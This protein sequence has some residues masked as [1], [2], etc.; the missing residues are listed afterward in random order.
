MEF[1][2]G[3]PGVTGFTECES[4][5]HLR[6]RPQVIAVGLQ[7]TCVESVIQAG[8]KAM[9][10]VR[11][12]ALEIAL[13]SLL[14]T[15]SFDPWFVSSSAALTDANGEVPR[16]TFTKE[17]GSSEGIELERMVTSPAGYVTGYFNLLTDD[18]LEGVA[19]TADA[20]S[21]VNY[22]EC[23]WRVYTDAALSLGYAFHEPLGTPFLEKSQTETLP[24]WVHALKCDA[25]PCTRND[26][27][28]M[29][30]GSEKP[31]LNISPVGGLLPP[32]IDTVA[33]HELGHVLFKSYNKF[34]NS[35][36]VSFLNEGLPAGIVKI[37]L[38]PDYTPS[39]PQVQ[40]GYNLKAYR[41][42]SDESVR[43]LGYG[44]HPFWYF[45]GTEYTVLADPDGFYP[46]A[47]VPE[48]CGQYGTA[49]KGDTA[50]RKIPGRDVILHIQQAFER[51]HPLG[52]E[53]PVCKDSSGRETIDAQCA[54][55]T[56]YPGSGCVPAD[57]P[58]WAERWVAPGENPPSTCGDPPKPPC[59][60][61]GQERVGEAMMPLTLQM[62][63]DELIAH[64]GMRPDGLSYQ[65]FR[66]FLV[67]NYLNKSG[68]GSDYFLDGTAGYRIKS[69]GAHYHE[70]DLTS[71]GW[72]VRIEKKS[73]LPKWAY[74]VFYVDGGTAIS[75]GSWD[76][77]ASD[78]ITIH[79]DYEKAVLV[80]TAFEG[81]YDPM[82]SL[83]WSLPYASSGGHYT[84]TKEA[85]PIAPDV[86]DDG[87]PHTPSPGTWVVDRNDSR[88]KATPLVMP[89]DPHK[90]RSVLQFDRL[91]FDQPGDRD[92]FRVRIPD[93]PSDGCTC[94]C[95]W[96]TFCSKRLVIS[97]SS[98]VLRPT[99]G[100]TLYSPSGTPIDPVAEGWA[101]WAYGGQEIEILCPKTAVTSG[102]LS[103][104]SAGGE[105]T[106]S[107]AP[108]HGLA[109]YNLEIRYEYLHCGIPAFVFKVG[110]YIEILNYWDET[111]HYRIY[112]GLREEF[113]GCITDPGCD[114]AE[115]FIA[116]NWDGSEFRMFMEY[117]SPAESGDLKVSLLDMKGKS[118]ATFVP[119]GYLGPPSAQGDRMGTADS[120]TSFREVSS[121]FPGG[122]TQGGRRILLPK[123]LAKGWYALKI[124][125]PYPTLYAFQVG[126]CKQFAAEKMY[127]FGGFK[128][129]KQDGSSSF[130]PGQ[131]V[132]IAMVLTDCYSKS[133][134]TAKAA[135]SLYR[136]AGSGVEEPVPVKPSQDNPNNLF[137]YDKK[138]GQYFFNLATK[139]F[140]KGTYK[141]YATMEGG[142]NYSV[143]FSIK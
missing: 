54:T 32:G 25:S 42:L 13:V 78:T 12:S 124:K 72:T 101:T 17:P 61:E 104:L 39:A 82:V 57:Y 45:L 22:V 18:P 21:T 94:A 1:F 77:H 8:R 92:Y 40:F 80:I 20:Q 6:R 83:D 108:S 91:N 96:D 119:M 23:A 55:S 48:V 98:S 14:F 51:C 128:Q 126:D 97:V 5:I 114:P 89:E 58:D 122:T 65:A 62:I 3:G 102:G 31:R 141:A 79:P 103:I 56:T 120:N 112:P 130:K 95:G 107:L 37:P 2:L 85:H 74:H 29:N 28:A 84:L 24:L 137:Q 121:F 135:F 87:N 67:W 106:F 30:S 49:I 41:G 38:D 90:E 138:K 110:E 99:I 60:S 109:E 59:N 131:S 71:G 100:I 113:Y 47:S 27:S 115:E 81:T 132:S 133:I 68:G 50:M 26:L 63:D 136:I 129:P 7:F 123:K 93:D 34:I 143:R 142:E 19:S 73:D 111:P 116:L 117:G 53:T 16:A 44:G 105:V 127:I 15:F 118:V 86:F 9:K 134:S 64:H 75:A 11:S 43:R 4:F 139:G 52:K 36:A 69:F 46:A 76:N 66:E 70:F 125:A 33:F 140:A 10:N 88:S 35:G